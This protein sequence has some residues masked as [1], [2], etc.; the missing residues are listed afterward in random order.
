MNFEEELLIKPFFN[1]VRRGVRDQPPPPGRNNDVEHGLRAGPSR[2]PKADDEI[3]PDDDNPAPPPVRDDVEL[4]LRAGPS[5]NPK[6]DD[7]IVLPDDDINPESDQPFFFFLSFFYSVKPN[8]LVVI[9][10]AS[11]YLSLCPIS[12][13]CRLS[14]RVSKTKK[15]QRDTS[16]HRK[17]P[18]KLVRWRPRRTITERPWS[19][20]NS[21]GDD[22]SLT[23]SKSNY[24]QRQSQSRSGSEPP[25]K[26]NSYS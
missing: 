9:Y 3:V 11:I 16:N 26:K 19:N 18:G 13:S 22:T 15:R 1:L 21:N 24:D 4:G 6:A 23:N 12:D 20:N 7:E 14:L 10:L 25:S 8:L 17:W 5:G 2:K